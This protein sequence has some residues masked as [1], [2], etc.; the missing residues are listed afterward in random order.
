M[1]ASITSLTNYI[2]GTDVS[3]FGN[4]DGSVEVIAVGAH[5]PYS[6]QWFGPNGFYSTSNLINSLYAETYSVTVS[7]TNNCTVNTSINLTE[8][9]ALIFTSL[10]S[11]DASCLGAC[12]GT[13]EI[14]LTG[15]TAPYS[16]HA[17]DNN[18][19]A[20]IMNLLSG[21]SLFTGICAGDYTISLSDAN[22]CASE[23]L[24]GG[25]DQQIID[26]LDTVSYTHLT[27]PTILLV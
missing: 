25:N 4:N 22:G 6:Y 9:A 1:S 8:P 16:G 23:L 21:D 2:G 27:L 18:T 17:Q 13:V 14:S 11:T 5:A 15:G 26:A 10:S 12:D 3:C 20:T 19:G 24:V 7:D